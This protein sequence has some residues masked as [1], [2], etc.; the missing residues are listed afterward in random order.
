MHDYRV[1]VILLCQQKLM[2]YPGCLIMVVYIYICTVKPPITQICP[3]HIN[4]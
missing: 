3:Y 2:Y 4:M 1:I